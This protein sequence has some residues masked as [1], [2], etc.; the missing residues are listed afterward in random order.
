[1]PALDDLFPELAGKPVA[2]TP[3]GLVLV[4]LPKGCVAVFTRAEYLAAV[5]RGKAVLR[6]RTLHRRL[7]AEQ[8]QGDTQVSPSPEKCR[9]VAPWGSGLKRLEGRGP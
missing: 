5:E 3:G 6:S 4:R 1:M 9:C 7:Q 8:A 2:F